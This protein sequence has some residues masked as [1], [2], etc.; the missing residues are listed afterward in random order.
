MVRRTIVRSIIY[1]LLIILALI[2][3]V[4]FYNMFINATHETMAISTGY[5][6]LPGKYLVKN[7]L[8]LTESVNLGR[9]FVNSLI[10]ASSCTF[11]SCYFG[12]MTAYG[13]AKFRFRL[14]KFFFW[15]ILIF[16]MVPGQLG[17]VGYFEMMIKFG[18]LDN[19]LSLIVPSIAS[20]GC[21]FFIRQYIVVI[22]S[23]SLLESARIDGCNEF[24]IFHWIAIPVIKPAIFTQAIFAFIGS[25]NSFMNPLILL[26]SKDKMTL[27]IV[28]QRMKGTYSTDLGAL[29]M[30][31]AI[32]VIPI[33]IFATFSM[34]RIMGGL[35]MGSVK[36]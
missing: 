32:S 8:R 20:S 16:M 1:L 14:N 27:P 29:N 34:K 35:T 26:F 28:I 9:G 10:I 13:L 6:L 19:Y 24:V 15:I 2:C 21:V 30:G 25:W 36:G 4:P 3:I 11:L 5:Q 7:F 17:I 18:W 31:L 23:D 22:L 33:L 12:A